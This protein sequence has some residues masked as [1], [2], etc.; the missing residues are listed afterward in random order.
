[1][2]CAQPLTSWGSQIDGFGSQC[3]ARLDRGERH[4][5]YER[6]VELR[7]IER[8][9]VGPV[10]RFLQPMKDRWHTYR[11]NRFLRE[12]GVGSH[13][14]ATSAISAGCDKVSRRRTKRTRLRRDR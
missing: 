2:A 4:G 7:A 14:F 10:G 5:L 6:S 9:E 12:G 13:E 3:Y 1:M 8:L 11:V